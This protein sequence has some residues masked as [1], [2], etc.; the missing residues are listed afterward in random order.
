MLARTA[1]VNQGVS[2]LHAVVESDV[3]FF[4]LSEHYTTDVWPH[5]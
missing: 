4:I 5:L 2:V 3:D 1:A